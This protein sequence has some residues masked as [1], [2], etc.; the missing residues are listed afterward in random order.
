VW[1]LRAQAA[2]GGGGVCKEGCVEVVHWQCDKLPCWLASLAVTDGFS[3]KSMVILLSYR[4]N[5]VR[6]PTDRECKNDSSNN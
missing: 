6:L 4:G 1:G 5:C 3:A 2:A